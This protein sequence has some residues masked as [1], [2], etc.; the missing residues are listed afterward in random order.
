MEEAGV[1]PL[2]C[3]S[4]KGPVDWKFMAG[5]YYFISHIRLSVK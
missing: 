2:P 5:P 1:M 3:K 4:P